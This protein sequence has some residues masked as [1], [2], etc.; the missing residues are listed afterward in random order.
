VSKLIGLPFI[1]DLPDQTFNIRSKWK[2]SI[3]SL[4][5]SPYHLLL[6][7]ALRHV[8]CPHPGHQPPPH[9]NC[10]CFVKQKAYRTCAFLSLSRCSAF[11]SWQCFMASALRVRFYAKVLHSRF[12][13]IEFTR[14]PAQRSKPSCPCLK[15]HPI[16]YS[17]GPSFLFIPSAVQLRLENLKTWPILQWCPTLSYCTRARFQFILQTIQDPPGALRLNCPW[18]QR[19]R[20]RSLRSN[21]RAN[22]TQL[23]IYARWV[24]VQSIQWLTGGRHS[25]A[26]WVLHASRLSSDHRSPMKS[27]I[28]RG[29]RQ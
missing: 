13:P 17:A 3:S 19:T 2:V 23:N 4:S 9:S 1:F 6:R 24:S 11:S 8:L 22:I 25:L 20:S 29:R 28:I 5:L 16:I 26:Q 18:Q 21:V 7:G 15:F 10:F 12:R 14:N 27:Q